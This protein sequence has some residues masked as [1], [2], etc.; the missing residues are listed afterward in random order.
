MKSNLI[1]TGL[2]MLL[3]MVISHTVKAQFTMT[4]NL[5]CRVELFYEARNAG[6]GTPSSGTI[7][8]NPTT[9][10]TF[11]PNPTIIGYCVVIRQIGGV[12]APGNHLW[13]TINPN[14]TPCHNVAYGQSGL[15]SNCGPYNVTLTSNS[16]TIN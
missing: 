14:F 3:M 7:I 5:H 1:R 8:M 2:F 6:C 12:T 13:I 11:T 15:T 16:W 9:S 10:V 4:N